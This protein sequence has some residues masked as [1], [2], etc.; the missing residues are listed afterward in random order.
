M[1]GSVVALG[2]GVLVEQVLNK[3]GRRFAKIFL[4][5]CHTR[6]VAIKPLRFAQST[7]TI[8]RITRRSRFEKE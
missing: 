2:P 8:T 4:S 1:G 3:C 5:P 6:G 7:N